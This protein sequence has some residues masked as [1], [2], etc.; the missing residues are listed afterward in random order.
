ML[1]LIPMPG[2]VTVTIPLL[3]GV[4]IE[5]RPPTTALIEQARFDARSSAL[6]DEGAREEAYT[7]ALLKAAVF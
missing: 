3:P 1:K 6:T 2:T 4:E 7:A 5:C